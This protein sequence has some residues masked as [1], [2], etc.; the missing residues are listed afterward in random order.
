MTYLSWLVKWIHL[1]WLLMFVQIVKQYRAMTW[2]GGLG[3]GGSG[4]WRGHKWKKWGNII[5]RNHGTFFAKIHHKGTFKRW[6][7]FFCYHIPPTHPL[8]PHPFQLSPDANVD[9]RIDR[10]LS[11]DGKLKIITI[12]AEGR[13]GTNSQN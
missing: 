3:G 2:K 4:Q 8:P 10:G 12:V 11:I 7:H 13:A 9:L 5:K 6:Q 1:Y